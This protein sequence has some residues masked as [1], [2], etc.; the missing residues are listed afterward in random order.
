MAAR[1]PDDTRLYTELLPAMTQDAV[2]AAVD[3]DTY[4]AAEVVRATLGHV[5]DPDLGWT[6]AERIIIWLHW[7]A[8]AAGQ[9][10]DLGL[11]EEVANAV[12]TW[13][14]AWD[15]WTPRK[16][17]R[18]WLVQLRGDQ[19]AAAARALREHPEAARHFAKLA[20]DRRADERIRRA[21]RSAPSASRGEVRPADT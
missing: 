16:Q 15:Q 20:D 7:V 4:Q 18:H 6:D 1:R 9:T 11:L 5:R 14:A 8:V 21:V 19:A 12:L 3:A 10:N 17:I 13:D 2:T